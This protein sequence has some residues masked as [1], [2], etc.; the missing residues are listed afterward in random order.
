MKKF[1]VKSVVLVVTVAALVAILN[2]FVDTVG[3]AVK[4]GNLANLVKT[5]GT[6]EPSITNVD[7][8]EQLVACSTLT[9]AQY[10]FSSECY[11]END[12]FLCFTGEECTFT[13]DGYVNA[14]I[15]DLSGVQVRINH[16]KKAIEVYMPEVEILGEPVIDY[17]SIE[18]IDESTGCFS[19]ITLEETV[20]LFE[21]C[22]DHQIE[23]ARAADILEEAEA[24]ARAIVEDVLGTFLADTELADYKIAVIFGIEAPAEHSS[25]NNEAVIPEVRCKEQ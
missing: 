20:D 17:S 25:Q 7:L 14:G 22:C 12:G 11:Y 4:G 15:D 2:P 8:E 3:E 18:V 16:E 23:R 6:T 9:T 13:Y 1:V 21:Q 10:E 19:D 24:Q 5:P